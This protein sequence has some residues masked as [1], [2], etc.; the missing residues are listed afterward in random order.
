MPIALN[1]TDSAG[2]RQ[3]VLGNGS[4]VVGG[5]DGCEVPLADPTVSRRHLRLEITASAVRVEDLGS[6]NGSTLDGAL[7]QAGVPM[8][9]GPKVALGLGDTL[10]AWSALTDEDESPVVELAA[11]ARLVSD[12]PE[13]EATQ[14]GATHH[15]FLS[16]RLPALLEL[17]TTADAL[18]LGRAVGEAL[19][20]DS[21][22]AA[23]VIE[24]VG[25]P[26]PA[27]L[28]RVGTV[29]DAVCTVEHGR[30]RAA[31][32]GEKP[33]FA[34]LL[35]T[36]LRVLA[37]AAE[38]TTSA[39]ERRA[40]TAPPAPATLEPA[41]Q[42]LYDKAA[43]AA[44][45]GLNV[46]IQGETG[47]GKEV[48]ARYIREEQASE[49][50]W[51][52]IN[53]AALPESL[54][55]AE[56]FGIEKGV[57][58]GVEARAGHFERAHGGVLFLDEIADMSLG[59]QAQILRV[60]EERRVRRVGGETLRPAEV[61]LVAA[62]NRPLRDLVEDG[63]FR[64][65]LFHRLADWEAVIPS[66]ADRP[67][68]IANLASHFLSVAAQELRKPIRGLTQGAVTR[69]LAHDWPGNV[70]ELQRE[71]HR[72]A[73]FAPDHAVITASDLGPAIGADHEAAGDLAS[74]VLRYERRIIARALAA[75]DDD[76]DAAAESLG[77]S[78]STLYRR[79]RATGLGSTSSQD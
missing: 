16:K 19:A 51:V 66:L 78:R 6:T 75:T 23:L 72:V 10:L 59:T 20:E 30:F 15:P 55:E 77:I 61:Q 64:R 17:A 70:R 62:S 42:R 49:G 25:E 68:D 38:G 41:V 43:Q 53:C 52:T 2:V 71:M 74:Q 18:T 21:S 1:I 33:D 32:D 58:T 45:A 73:A 5:G 36:A 14:R 26:P 34:A 9:W 28:F 46:L 4:V 11:P 22:V 65:D 56:L 50:G 60:I 44:R 57:A 24:E 12:R 37:L 13:A 54:L 40:P 48:L 3:V 29:D 69:L 79:L 39:P 7:L 63:S 47:A 76:V 8:T 27:T 35:G 31:A 67:R